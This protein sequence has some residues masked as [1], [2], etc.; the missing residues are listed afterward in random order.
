MSLI[1]SKILRMNVNPLTLRKVINL[2]ERWVRNSEAK[3][4]C[5]SNVHMCMEVFDKKNYKKIVNNSD[6]TVPDG[7]PIFW[8]LRLLGYKNAQQIRGLDLTLQVC[9]F[10]NK[11]NIPIG[12]FGSNK[13]T[14]EKIKKN[15]KSLYPKLKIY[16]SESPPFRKLSV[17]E[18]L[19][20]I[21]KINKSGIKI[22]FL[23]LGCPK[24]EIWMADN[25]KKL[26]CTMI[27]VGAAFDF[28]AGSKMVAPKWIQYI[29]MEWLLRFFCEP[30]RLWRR[31]YA[32]NIR[33]IALFIM[34]LLGR[35]F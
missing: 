34:Q 5:V 31:Y 28:I 6:L 22:L 29:G 8:G 23:G 3:Y 35:K 33:Y 4:I 19:N 1:V 24:Q 20:Y 15:L 13:I 7:R 18:N 21:K 27:G 25:K 9:S 12:F 26:K 11:K 10:A 17:T 14:Q 32:N 2:I 16:F 30:K